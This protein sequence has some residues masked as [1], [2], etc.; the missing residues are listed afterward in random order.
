MT[1]DGPCFFCGKTLTEA[2]GICLC[3]E[4]GGCGAF[5]EIE[6][7]QIWWVIPQEQVLR[8]VKEGKLHK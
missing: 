1:D 3:L 8:L 4:P 7:D 5:E 6:G 2:D